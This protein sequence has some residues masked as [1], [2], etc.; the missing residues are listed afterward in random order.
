[1]I[2]FR[3]QI[4]DEFVERVRQI[5][6][7]DGLLAVARNFEYRPE[8]QQMAV[9]VARALSEESHLVV[10][11]GTGVGKSLAYLVPSILFALERQKKAVISTYTINLQ[12]QL[13]YK[14][15]PILQKILPVEFEVALWK[16][17]QN[18]LCPRRLERAMQ[19]PGDL[20]TSPEQ[21][22]L[23]R[24]WEWSQTTRDG[25]LADFAVEPDPAVWA[26]VCSEP[27]LCT[28]K[29]CGG[30]ESRCFYQQARKRLLAADVVVM[31][32]TL[33]FLNAGSADE[34]A[35]QDGYIFANDF[36]IFDEAH[37]VESVAAKQIGLNVSQFGLKYA[38]QRLYNERTKKGLFTALRNPDGVREVTALL[39]TVDQFFETV[40][41]K[42]PFKGKGREVR[43]RQPD[44]VPDTITSKLA[45]LQALI[46]GV[47]KNVEDE[48]TKGE[49][50][51]MG[52]KVRD[53]RLAIATFLSQTA[54]DHVYWVEKTGRQ[55]QFCA[56]NAAPVDIAAHL[57][58]MLFKEGST[59]VMTSA[60]L[61]VGSAEMHYFRNRVGAEEVT[62]EQVG[63]PF[64]YEKQMRL[65]VTRKMPDPRDAGYEEA[66][67]AQVE[68]FV[69]MSRGR[70]FVLFTSYKTLQAMAER[71]RK[72]FEKKGWNLLV[73]GQGM[74]RHRLVEDFKKEG[75][76]NVLF[77]TDSFWSGVDVPGE[78]LSNVIITRL[79]FAVPDHPLIEARLEVIQ[80]QG[81]DPFAEYSLP[82]AILKLR[83]GVGRLIRTKSDTGIVVILDP[84]ILTKGYG[85]AFLKAL[86][87]CPVEVV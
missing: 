84:R 1:M 14:D 36:V 40:A 50:Q 87:K 25:S 49:L 20:F 54:E 82:E 16:G 3:E 55:G 67:A 75:E 66:L 23:K 69:E 59:C 77:G 32:H 61:S 72:P 34:A 19:S 63:S 58:A 86:P 85:S 48:I 28:V 8:Q 76:P 56:L 5:F 18:Y 52:R 65:Y 13:V 7:P 46:V 41:E 78:A 12:E 42:A 53:A 83:Q 74:S 64:D 31:N 6:A 17:R 4:G 9:A 11:A 26:Q 30:K 43:I 51:E 21:E 27:H 70:A 73:Q 44:M 39:E 68:K 35:E 33:F 22:E 80:A 29:T 37:T 62:A 15:I 71:L 60:T 2:A 45:E 47:L 38:L 79:P 57:R 10:E 81:G 24:I